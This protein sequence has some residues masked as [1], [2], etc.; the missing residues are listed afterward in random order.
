MCFDII[1]LNFTEESDFMLLCV[2]TGNVVDRLGFEKG[3]AAIREAGFE[4]IDWNLDH[5]W[6][7]PNIRKGTYLGK[8]IM[9]KPLEDVIAYYAE[10]LEIIRKNGL[11]ISQAHA[12]FPAW[13]IEHP[14]VLDYSIEIYKRNIEY[15][16]YAG[17]KNLVIHGISYNL[18]NTEY[19]L[20]D[21][22]KLNFKLYSSLIPTLLKTNVTVCLENLFTGFNGVLY[23][24][25][26]A[27]PQAAADLIDKLNELAGKEVFGFCLDTGHLNI[28]HEDFR[29]AVPVLGKRIKAL[30]IHDN[31]GAHDEHLMPLTGTINWKFFCESLHSVGYDGDL[32]FETFNQTDIV[33]NFDEDMVYPWLKLISSI[34]ESFRK[35][36]Q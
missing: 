19:T 6:E 34:G 1:Q 31:D 7:I 28:L 10:E 26:C 33:M 30:H 12:P 27:I 13:V 35:K 5:A 25:H 3:Y 29:V 21:M 20:E 17:C 4:A 15:C 14:E 24:G 2:Q 36:I 18:S 8:S 16:D 23:H 9:E 32:D 22:E 11:V